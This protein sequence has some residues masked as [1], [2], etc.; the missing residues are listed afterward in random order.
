VGKNDPS[1]RKN[2]FSLS[3]SLSL[4]REFF[5]DAPRRSVFLSL[6]FPSDFF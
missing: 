4:Q 3:L 5:G 1:Q 2:S 6:F